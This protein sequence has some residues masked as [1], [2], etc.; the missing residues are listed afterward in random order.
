MEIQPHIT[1]CPIVPLTKLN[2]KW[3][4]IIEYNC[5]KIDKTNQIEKNNN[6]KK[7]GQVPISIAHTHT[8]NCFS[9]TINQRI[10]NL[11]VEPV[12]KR[13]YFSIGF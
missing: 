1:S 8:P 10:I 9:T 6:E 11:F 7:L 3:N 13:H 4:K 12:Y 5:R 2:N